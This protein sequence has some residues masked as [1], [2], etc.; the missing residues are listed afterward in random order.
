MEIIVVI[1]IL[2]GIVCG[3]LAGSKGRS[4]PAWVLLGACFPLI[5]L[6][7]LVLMSDLKQAAAD[8]AAAAETE[9]ERLRLVE[10]RKETEQMK[11]CPRC[12]EKVKAAA[13]VCR[14]CGHEFQ[15]QS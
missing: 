1:A 7:I 8:R 3:L 14:Y 4:V 10:A 6:L 9:R 15:T 12:A 2:G 13:M 5:S 11:T